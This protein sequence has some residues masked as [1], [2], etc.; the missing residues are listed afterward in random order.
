MTF[1]IFRHIYLGPHLTHG[2][3]HELPELARRIERLE[4][5]LAL[6]QDLDRL[7]RVLRQR[8]WV[9][10]QRTGRSLHLLERLGY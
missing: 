3:Y 2:R 7:I 5:F 9:L 4:S 1:Q 8:V 6:L 10:L